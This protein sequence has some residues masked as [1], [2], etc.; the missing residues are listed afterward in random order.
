MIVGVFNPPLSGGEPRFWG[1]EPPLPQNPWGGANRPQ[2]SPPQWGGARVFWGV[3][4]E[5]WG[6]AILSRVFEAF[7]KISRAPPLSGGEPPL[8]EQILGGAH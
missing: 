7:L 1:G 8:R 5:A 6:G 4:F 2:D 3:L